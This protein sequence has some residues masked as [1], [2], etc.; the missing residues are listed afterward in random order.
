MSLAKYIKA[1]IHVDS[2]LDT[3][4]STP[5]WRP[6]PFWNGK[7][8]T[9]FKP[10][11]TNHCRLLYYFDIGSKRFI[12]KIDQWPDFLQCE[13]E[14]ELWKRLETSDKR[15]FVPVM[16]GDP[17]PRDQGPPWVV[18]PLIPGLSM[19]EPR[20]AD[21]DK[22]DEL[23]EKYNLDDIRLNTNWFLYN[24]RPLIV[25]YGLPRR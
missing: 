16:C 21:Y 19:R 5:A 25:D 9:T 8:M 11:C 6:T 15:F 20:P 23:E 18:C 4:V 10:M 24:R 3:T 13:H 17:D 22:I 7:P 12:M 1:R 14:L 2:Y